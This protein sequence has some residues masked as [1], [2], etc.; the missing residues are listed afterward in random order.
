MSWSLSIPWPLERIIRQYVG[1]NTLVCREYSD[2]IEYD[3]RLKRLL[4]KRSPK[5]STVA[6]WRNPTN[7]EI[8]G[9]DLYIYH[10]RYIFDK[11]WNCNSLVP[12]VKECISLPRKMYY[13][14]NK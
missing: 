1:F 9:P 6:Q 2:L 13:D 8:R 11:N 14:F 5:R 3:D 10:F 12:L 4:E 7:I